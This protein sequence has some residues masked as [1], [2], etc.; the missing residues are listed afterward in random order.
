MVQNIGSPGEHAGCAKYWKSSGAQDG[1]TQVIFQIA[2]N[3][4]VQL[5][6]VVIVEEARRNRPP[7]RRHSGFDGHIRKRSISV[8]VIE[9]IV[10]VVSHVEVGKPVV[11]VIA[12]RHAHAVVGVGFAVQTRLFRH[13]K[14]VAIFILA[15]QPVPVGRIPPREP[16]RTLHRIVQVAAVHEEDVQ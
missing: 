10:A 2:C 13:I 1:V 14:E 8:V 12:R 16:W 15:I 7:A 5:P 6:V 11:I 9:H 4:E 3:E